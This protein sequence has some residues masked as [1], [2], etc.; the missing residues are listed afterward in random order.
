MTIFYSDVEPLSKYSP[1]TLPLS[2]ATRIRNENPVYNS[3]VQLFWDI[4]YWQLKR[5]WLLNSTD[6][7]SIV[8]NR[9][10]SVCNSYVYRKIMENRG[11]YFMTKSLVQGIL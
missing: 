1:V 3:F 10:M 6:G 2:S 5:G 8:R 4:D 11:I 7:G 9:H